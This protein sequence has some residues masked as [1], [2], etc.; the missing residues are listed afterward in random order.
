MLKSEWES[1]SKRKEERASEREE[2]DGGRRREL[3]VSGLMVELGHSPPCCETNELGVESFTFEE[4]ETR[5]SPPFI[6]T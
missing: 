5:P 4:R 6:A 1:A 2:R 3:S